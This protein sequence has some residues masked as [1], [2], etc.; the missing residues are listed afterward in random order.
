MRRLPVLAGLLVV[1]TAC[2]DDG[3]SPAADTA[4]AD[5]GVTD[6]AGADALVDDVGGSDA[7]STDADVAVDDASTDAAGDAAGDAN[8][9]PPTGPDLVVVTFNIKGDDSLGSAFDEATSWNYAID[10]EDDRR[11]RVVATLDR[12]A[13]D[14]VCLQEARPGPVEYMLAGAAIPY[15]HHGEERG[16]ENAP[17]DMNG[18]LYRTDR[19][20][21]VDGGH[22]W[23]SDTPDEAGTTFEARDDD[24]SRMASWA[25]FEDALGG[26]QFTALCTH[27]SLDSGARQNAA[28]LIRDRLLALGSADAPTL[29]LGDLN[30]TEGDREVRILRGEEDPDGDL[31]VDAYRA[32]VPDRASDERTYHAFEGITDGS[33]I[34]FVLHDDAF[35]ATDA[36]IDRWRT[37]RGYPSDHYP[38]RVVLEWAEST[39]D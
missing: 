22:F 10:D 21:L 12:L 16:G 11:D 38:V 37:D 39:G 35:V 30:A 9:P 18:L 29:V 36:I 31:Y 24:N 2:G 7:G 27:W 3:S 25:K 4:G 20:T 5:A 34:D 28:R 33:R 14:L 19:L 13:G 8:D 26:Q 1:A 15:A 23:L 32:V 17:S 6:A